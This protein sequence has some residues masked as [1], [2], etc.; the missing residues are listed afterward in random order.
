M[1]A[2]QYNAIIRKLVIGFGNLF[3]QI[4]IARFENDGTEAERFLVPIAY[5][6]KENYLLRLQGDP[7]L[8]KKVQI[9][10]PTMSFEM[11]GMKYDA[12]RKQTTNFKNFSNLNGQTIAQYNPVPY[13]FDFQLY[14][15]VRNTED[16]TQIV[17][18]I[19]PYFTPDYTI[20]L[21]LIPE[22]GVTKEVPIVLNDISQDVQYEGDMTSKV[23]I[24]VW[25]LSFTV[26]GFLY[27]PHSEI[28]K[29]IKTVITNILDN[30][31]EGISSL[32]A[33]MDTGVGNYQEG[34]HVYQ[35]AS[36]DLSSAT[37]IVIGWNPDTNK[38]ILKNLHGNFM[39]SHPII[40]KNTGTTRTFGSYV[41]QPI[42]E[43]KITVRPNPFTANV[44]DPYTYTTTIQE[45][46]NIIPTV[47]PVL[48]LGDDN[49]ANA[50]EPTASAWVLIDG[51][52]YN[53]TGD[54]T[55]GFIDGYS[56]RKMAPVGN[57]AFNKM[58]YNYGTDHIYWNG[59][60]WV[61]ESDLRGIVATGINGQWPWEATWTDDYKAA[62]IIGSYNK[63]TNYPVVP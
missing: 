17:E 49:P 52:Y 24:I 51:P 28:G 1:A 39:V 43:A 34:E 18:R 41:I 19:A 47:P 30:S 6:G 15:Y 58:T 4:Q 50:V 26:K 62:K 44:N 35:G 61:Y 60:N 8:Y 22:M 56:W 33:H 14:V 13:D 25:T 40:G 36:G 55:S 5:A 29:I 53:V 11:T 32:V 10:L 31:N 12:S 2:I 7:D 37:A 48:H 16:G 54:P 59:S 27:G 9:T 42:E 46:P 38:L 45:I 3:N 23:R 63:S 57:N 21:N 20:K